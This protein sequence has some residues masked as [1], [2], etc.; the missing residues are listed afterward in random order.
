MST[1]KNNIT[2]HSFFLKLALIQAKKKLG[3]TKIN[4]SV[5]C[6]I[7]KNNHV[8]G[9]GSTGTN[10]R[11]HAETNAISST[12]TNI[13]GSDIYIT[14][15]PCSHYG[16]TPPCVNMIIKNGIKRVYFSIKDPDIRSYNKSYIK[17]KRKG[18]A[19]KQGIN[20]SEINS[21]FLILKD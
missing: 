1:K 4:P 20:Y 15:E 16:K 21:F 7:V 12:K 9:A 18:I 14:L 2:K 17:F 11:P 3:N 10:G 19:A 5:G 6:I 13:I 8:I